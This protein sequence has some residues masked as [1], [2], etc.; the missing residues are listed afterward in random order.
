MTVKLAFG[1]DTELEAALRA[2]GGQVV[3]ADLDRF[4][5][6]SGPLVGSPVRPI[7]TQ[8]GHGGKEATSGLIVSG[9][10]FYPRPIHRMVLR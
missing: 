3:R 1:G 4:R 6:K 8:S 2:L 9:L 7:V 10:P 5:P